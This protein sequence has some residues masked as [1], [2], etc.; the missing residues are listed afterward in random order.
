MHNTEHIE[1]ITGPVEAGWSEFTVWIGE[2]SWTCNASYLG[3]HPLS[4]LIHLAVDI[5]E[6]IVENADCEGDDIWTAWAID[7]PGGIVVQAAPVN[8]CKLE[9]SVFQFKKEDLLTMQKDPPD[10]PPN[11]ECILEYWDFAKAVFNDAARAIARQGI[12]GF[13]HA[14]EPFHW[15]DGFHFTALPV[16]Q[17]FYL[18]NLVM[19]GE[20]KPG[21]SLKE[22]IQILETVMRKIKN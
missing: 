4:Q 14:W 3:S 7:E 22:E 19:D 5:H 2:S 1:F 6:H 20:K 15:G 11:G 17:F 9:M 21:L 18:A 12:T 8:G 13:R 16:E 10:I